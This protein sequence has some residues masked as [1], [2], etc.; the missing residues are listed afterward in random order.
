MGT[1][2]S[3][4]ARDFDSAKIK[5]RLCFLNGRNA[6]D[7][8]KIT[9]DTFFIGRSQTNN[10]ILEDRSV[11][12]KHAVLNFLDGEF[13]LSDLNSYKG[14]EL[15]GE[16]VKEVVLRDGDQIRFGSVALQFLLGDSKSS[17]KFSRRN[18]V[19]YLFL[20]IGLAGMLA[21]YFL[22]GGGT[23]DEKM[24]LARELEYNYQEGVK[25]YNQD[26]NFEGA[27][28]YWQRVLDLDPERESDQAHKA[29]ILLKNLHAEDSSNVEG[30][31][32]R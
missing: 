4:T 15:N 14:I 10:L 21:A 31:I 1:D 18:I 23:K 16:K 5:A 8:V 6:G 26:K 2:K 17:V 24:D 12:R 19:W 30:S 32:S 29:A 9:K 27:A 3:I 28:L 7:E 20:M 13:V 22:S 11:S 25:A